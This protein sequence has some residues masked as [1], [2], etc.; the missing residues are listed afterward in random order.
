MSTSP[1]PP[2]PRERSLSGLSNEDAYGYCRAVR[3]RDRV[4]VSGMTATVPGGAVAPEHA[5]DTYAQAKESLR[6]IGEALASFGLGFEHV[7]KTTVFFTDRDAVADVVK[8]HGEVFGD[9]KPASTAVGV[10]GLFSPAAL[11]EIE[12]EAIA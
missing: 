4:V 5:G 12:A 11:V 9:T 2:T 7:V 10:S 3:V 1:A 6:R 8:A